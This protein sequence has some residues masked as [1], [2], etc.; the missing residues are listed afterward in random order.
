[1]F[2]NVESAENQH[3]EE[4]LKCDI[5]LVLFLGNYQDKCVCEPV[6]Q[7]ESV[8]FIQMKLDENFWFTSISLL[9]IF[10]PSRPPKTRF[11]PC[12]PRKGYHFIIHED[13]YDFFL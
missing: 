12:P 8:C 10:T 3:L 7:K 4:V 6:V 9:I 5:F 1:M 13:A 11:L 2:N